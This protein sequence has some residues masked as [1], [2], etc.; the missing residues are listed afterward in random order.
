MEDPELADIRISRRESDVVQEEEKVKK[1]EDGDF[2][3]MTKNLTKI[4]NEGK[5]DEKLAVNNVSFHV[6]RG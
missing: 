3:I 5:E 6:D 2:Q 4:Y 1:A